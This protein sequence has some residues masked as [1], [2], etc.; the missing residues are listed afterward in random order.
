MR[1]KLIGILIFLLCV[2]SIKHE[3][4]IHDLRKKYNVLWNCMWQTSEAFEE[5]QKWGDGIHG[6]QERIYN[7]SKKVDKKLRIK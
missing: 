3:L 1:K 5:I 6:W 2:I 7:W 4:N